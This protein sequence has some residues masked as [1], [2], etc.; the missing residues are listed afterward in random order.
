MGLEGGG[1]WQQQR[2]TGFHLSSSYFGK[3]FADA[4]QA[5]RELAL[6]T[7]VFPDTHLGS[8]AYAA[9][10]GD[11]IHWRSNSSAELLPCSSNLLSSISQDT[12]LAFSVPY[13]E[14]PDFLDAVQQIA[15][16]LDLSVVE[17]AVIDDEA[18]EKRWIMKAANGGSQGNLRKWVQNSWV[19]FVDLIKVRLKKKISGEARS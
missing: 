4:V 16:P 12:T 11:T 5:D 8:L 6:L 14:A 10:N 18:R 17:E 2:G 9:P 3:G 15:V 1:E 19:A 7:L 13:S